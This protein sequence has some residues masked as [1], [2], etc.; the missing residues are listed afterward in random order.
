MKPPFSFVYLFGY[1]QNELYF[2]E[3]AKEI[4]KELM[5]SCE[6]HPDNIEMAK[7]IASVN[8]VCVHARRLH[9]I[10]NGRDIQRTEGHRSLPIEYYIG[11]VAKICAEVSNPHFF[12]F[13]DAP[14][15]FCENLKIKYPVTYVNSNAHNGREYEDLWLM[16]ACKHFIIANST[17][18]WWGAWLSDF[19]EKIVIC[20]DG[21]RFE[22]GAAPCDG[23]DVL[24]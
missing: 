5:I 21:R 22:G 1:W 15:W 16:S 17:F 23:W 8:A 9:G 3:F 7:S 6:H 10:V 12:L 11:A 24:T 19:E 18:S 14:D 20:P 13:A 2:R 4:R